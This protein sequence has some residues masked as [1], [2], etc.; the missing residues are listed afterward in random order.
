VNEGRVRKI[1]ALMLA[2]FDRGRVASLGRAGGLGAAW[3]LAELLLLAALAYLP[4][5]F[6]W[7]LLTAN[8]ADQATIPLGDFTELHYPYRS[9]AAEELAR[10]RLPTWNPYV[11]AGH[12]ALG[13]VQFGLLY[14]VGWL[15]ARAYG[16]DLT[17]LGLEQQVVLHFGIATVGTYL[18]ARVAGA[19][20]AGAVLA[21][22]VFAFGGYMTSFPVQQIII[23]FTSVWLPWILLGI[24]LSVGKREPL[25]GLLVAAAVAAAALVGHPQTLAYVLGAA[26][27]YGLY[28]VVT[29]RSVFGT[30]GA[31]AGGLVGLGLAA[32]ALLPALEHLRLTAR[33]DVGYQFTAHGFSAHELLG[34]AYPTDLGGRPLYVGVLVLALALV[35]AAS[36]RVGVGF[37]A[38]LAAVALLLSLGGNA[39]LYPASYAL[40]PGLQYFRDHERAS[41]LVNL[42]LAMLAA[43][44]LRASLAGLA[45]APLRAA[46]LAALVV[47]G[48]FGLFGLL[49][50]YAV[51]IYEGDLRNKLNLIGDRAFLTALFGLLGGALL[52]GLRSRAVQS[53]ML[54]SAAVLLVAVDLFTAGWQL[55]LAPGSPEGILRATPTVQF[56]KEHLAPL[57]RVSTEGHLP[58]DGN[59]GALFRIPDLVGNSPLDLQSYR[60]FGEKVP[61]LE[62]WRMLTVRFITTRRK[63]D[64]PRL[65]VVFREGEL[66]T[67]E[68]R[69]DLRLPR[70][71]LVHRAIVAPTRDEELELA[72]RV[73][74]DEEVVVDRSVGPLDGRA[75]TR[76]P[77]EGAD[78]AIRAYEPDHLVLTAWSPRDAVLVLGERDYPGWRATIDGQPAPLLRANYLLRGL[79]LPGGQHEVVLRFEPPGLAAGQALAAEAVWWATLLV[80]LRLLLPI[81]LWAGRRGAVILADRIRARA[82]PSPVEES[83]PAPGATSG[84]PEPTGGAR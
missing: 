46:G 56:L 14:P 69:R 81:A 8:P 2:R 3:G 9:W 32:P 64:D 58:A 72:R 84:E 68:L 34:L 36:R 11:S 70:A 24:E 40:V 39:F 18:F 48:V 38:G 26:G 50:Q 16:G 61:E 20:R 62:R 5:V 57:D 76:P 23:L 74:P 54:A 7:R 80:A 77:A 44:G 27:A 10:G 37:W 13:D 21:A 59:A 31:A 35:G 52:F 12:P 60:V 6:F 75:P 78:V 22:L 51:V 28:R 65:P 67:H 83:T 49:V 42:A 19:G 29:R 1:G 15:F 55:N 63:I 17:Y 41:M 66:V 79:Y 71:W 33:T 53:A 47:A 45:V 30:I 4:A 73:K 82:R 25:A 43:Y